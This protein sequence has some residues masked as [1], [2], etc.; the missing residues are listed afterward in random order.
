MT[1]LFRNNLR[2]GRAPAWALPVVLFAVILQSCFTGIESTPKITYKD[3]KRQVVATPERQFALNFVA[4]SFSQWQPG[5]QFLMADS[6]G[7]LTY[8][9]PAGKIGELAQ[10]D[11]I[12]FRC[13][14]TVPSILGEEAAELIFTPIYA[15]TDTFIYRPGGSVAELQRRAELNLPFMVDLQQVATAREA[16][17]GKEFYTRTDRWYSAGESEL[18][19]RKFLKVKIIS[20]DAAN[21][22]Y[23]YFVRFRSAEGTD[24]EGGMLMAPTV[25]EG[26]PALRGFESLF[27]L[28]N[29]RGN[30]PNIT[31]LRWELIR[32]G[33]VEIGM[34]TQEAQ[35][36]LGAPSEVDKRPD[37]SILY[38]RWSYPGGIYLIFEDGLLTRT[39]L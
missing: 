3:V 28:E 20:V 10:G 17:V 2:I 37:Q 23:P 22:N 34:T 19:G 8:L 32:Q 9:P 27:L 29:P 33:K 24:E 31:D 11:T 21:E 38:E 25:D 18:K 7:S 5:R 16:L 36:S 13:V 15:E 14:R 39:N 12:L 26:V 4:D 35:L 6:R 30:Y 1:N